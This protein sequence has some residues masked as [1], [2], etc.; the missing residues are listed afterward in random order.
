MFAESHILG[1]S[2]IKISEKGRIVLPAFTYAEENDKVLICLSEDRNYFRIFSK[3]NITNLLNEMIEKQKSIYDLE[4][5]KSINYQIQHFQSLFVCECDIDKQR[6]IILPQQLRQDLKLFDN[7]YI[8]GSTDFYQPCL[9]VY[10][11]KE[12]MLK[13]L[14]KIRHYENS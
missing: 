1:Q 3:N 7:L 10:N 9:D 5:L 12:D 11:K 6:R 13:R 4:I 8:C 2:S 14:N